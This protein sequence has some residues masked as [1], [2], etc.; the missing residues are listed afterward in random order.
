MKDLTSTGRIIYSITFFGFGIN[1]FIQGNNMAGYVPPWLPVP[2]FWVYFVG[3]CLIAAG[4]SIITRKYA[5]LACLLLALLLLIIIL[6]I[7]IPGLFNEQTMMM[8]MTNL[9]KDLGL[10]GAALVLAGVF[11]LPEPQK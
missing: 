9:L 3:L 2:V 4:I 10:M 5:R 1:H 7:H 8:S 11:G 6:T